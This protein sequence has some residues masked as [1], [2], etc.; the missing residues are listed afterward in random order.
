LSG[1]LGVASFSGFS[2][3][4]S[5][6]HGGVEKQKCDK[7][8]KIRYKRTKKTQSID[9]RCPETNLGRRFKWQLLRKSES[10]SRVM[11]IS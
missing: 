8:H 9:N 7:K 6:T 4:K 1:K 10:D 3:S 11:I 5:E 2:M